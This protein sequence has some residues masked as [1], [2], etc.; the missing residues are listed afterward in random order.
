MKLQEMRENL[1]KKRRIKDGVLRDRTP[2]ARPGEYIAPESIP[3]LVRDLGPGVLY[4]ASPDDLRA[5][6]SRLPPDAYLGVR[7][8]ELCLGKERIN[9]YVLEEKGELTPDPLTGRSGWTEFEGIHGPGILGTRFGDGTIQLYAYVQTKEVPHWPIVELYLRKCMLSTFL[10]ELAHHQDA[11]IRVARGRWRM[12]DE[13]RDESYANQKQQ[14]W[15]KE[16]VIP[17]LEAAHPEQVEDLLR[18]VERHAGMRVPLSVLFDLDRDLVDCFG[19][20]IEGVIEGEEP[21]ESAIRLAQYLVWN[22]NEGMGLALLEHAL[23]EHA[24]NRD[25][26]AIKAEAFKGLGRLDLAIATAHVAI[27]IGPHEA[28]PWWILFSC[29]RKQR[30]WLELLRQTERADS[31][32]AS[33]PKRMLENLALERAVAL[34]NLGRYGEAID[35]VGCSWDTLS[36][37]GKASRGVLLAVALLGCGRHEEVLSVCKVAVESAGDSWRTEFEACQFVAAVRLGRSDLVRAFIER[38][39][40]AREFY[41]ITPE[42]Y[43]ELLESWLPQCR[44]QL[45][46][47]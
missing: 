45:G 25:A 12:D 1:H 9:E 33:A 34:I 27:G 14:Q 22:K 2:D 19:M 10:H 13:D 24:Q 7:K 23:P 36:G 37:A 21:T 6:M 30:A 3:I 29:L 5:L 16:H 4:P 39:S 44:A 32:L 18:W 38:K 15:T 17:C 28:G 20:F 35:L 40:T 46:L 8:I 26:H 43:P 42:L 41:P 47:S 11:M 31:M